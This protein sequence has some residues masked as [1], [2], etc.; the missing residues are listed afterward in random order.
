[1]ALPPA[2]RVLGRHYRHRDPDDLVHHPECPARR[3][4]QS[5][6]DHESVESAVVLPGVAGNVGLLRSLDGGSGLAHADRHW[7]DVHSY[8]G[9]ESSRERLLHFQAT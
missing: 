6:A 8:Y 4:V 7:T 1:M 9:P 3:A 5:H 2:D